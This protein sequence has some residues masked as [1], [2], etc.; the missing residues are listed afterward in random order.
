M[1]TKEE[2]TE[3]DNKADDHK[4]ASKGSRSR[5][6]RT[7]IIIVEIILILLE[8][9][10][11]YVVNKLDRVQRVA[12]S[13]DELQ[14]N[15]SEEVKANAESGQ[16]KGYTNIAL[17]GVDTR[18]GDLENNTRS[19][20][21]LIA[22]IN[23]TTKEVKLVSVFRDTYLNLGNDS[24]NKANS[25][26]A[27][28]GPTQAINMLNMNLDLNITDFI[29]V[30]FEGLVDVIDALGGIDIELTDAEVKHLNDYQKIMARQQG[31]E[32]IAVTQAGYQHLN[33]LQ[34]T[35]YCRI[36]YTSGDDF[37]RTERQREVLEK[38]FEA[39]SKA[40][41]S[42]LNSII[43]AVTDEI[44]TSLSTSEILGYVSNIT[45]YSIVDTTG[46][47]TSDMRTGATVGRKGSCVIP[48]TLE[49]NVIWLHEYLFG[50]ENYS[51][52]SK[53]LE[54][55]EKIQSDSGYTLDEDGN[56]VSGYRSQ[57][58]T[59]TTTTSGTTTT[60]ST[61]TQEDTTTTTDP[62]AGLMSMTDPNTGA[63]VW[64]DPYTGAVID[65]ATGQPTGAMADPATGNVVY[66]GGSGS[67]QNTTTDPNAQTTTPA[68]TD[69]ATATPADPSATTVD[70]NAAAPAVDPSTTTPDPNATTAAP[71]TTN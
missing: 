12:I 15:I 27:Q 30:G 9:A 16:M 3:T 61:T 23:N 13:V 50:E 4:K 35:A 65:P 51:P 19:D 56:V 69:P 21:I 36:R 67:G 63:T 18:T 64:Y 22:S 28:G 34:A 54:Y 52:S 58:T 39:A 38:V 10:V 7:A 6:I 31:K 42:E 20:T 43:D 62:Y 25:A 68:V 29:T 57:S 66:P 70:P 1:D 24:Y 37:K 32:Y 55:S 41:L 46:I 26:Y 48:V 49:A 71:A 40:S 45:S 11:L 59:T 47:P 17:F 33:G 44:Y 53:V 8:C 14:E 2:I 60:P 5:K